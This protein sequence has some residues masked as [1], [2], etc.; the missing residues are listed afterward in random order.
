MSKL[1]EKNG[2]QLNATIEK[3]AA[4]T[5][6]L[7]DT[8]LLPFD[9][10]ASKAH[11]KALSKADILSTN[12]LPKIDAA[13]SELEKEFNAGKIS[14]TQEDE[15]CHTM[16]EN[17]LVAKI[18]DV[19]KKI[20]TGR[21]RND[22]VLVA[23]RL[24]MKKNLAEMRGALLA[25]AS[26]FLAYAQKYKK[27]PMPG[28]THT[29]QA[30]L[31]SI[32]HYMASFAESAIDD[33][34]LLATIEKHIGK[35]PLGAAAGFGTSIHIDRNLTTKELGFSALQMN[36]LYTQNSRGKFESLYAEGLAQIMLTL[37]RFANDI[38]L[39]TSQEF[40]YF[41]VD[42]SLVTGSS[43]MPQKRNLD[44][45]EIVRG[46]VSVV[47]A[48]QLMIKDITKNLISGYN[49]DGQLIKKP[50]VESTNIV[51]ESIEVASLVLKGLTPKAENIAAKI[52]PGIFAAD[53]A[54]ELVKKRV[55][56]RDAY[57]RAAA[58]IVQKM[59]DLQ[60]NLASKTTLGAPGNLALESY[61]ARIKK[62]R[63]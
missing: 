34:E 53:A 22:Q 2:V 46:N 33:V 63:G 39:F 6:A 58:S 13:L 52:T 21:S 62:L 50:L 41:S 31:S 14:I 38:L 61:A 18:G 10:A 30:M 25:L 60:K 15:D 54:N 44:V 42:E 43:I 35:N 32:G 59:P 20:H 45:M 55:P 48:N 3:Y 36:S 37:G 4:G 49:R 9:I 26:D 28:Y 40:D 5:D 57:K 19:G 29:Q 12:E 7:F 56:F 47:I 11:A 51:A 23:Q 16:I 1:W 27:T 17:Y 8:Y 24:Y